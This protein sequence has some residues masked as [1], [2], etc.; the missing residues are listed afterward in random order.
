VVLSGGGAT[1]GPYK[2]RI[3]ILRDRSVRSS[4]NLDTVGTYEIMGDAAVLTFSRREHSD[5]VMTLHA[6][7]EMFDDTT[8]SIHANAAYRMEAIDEPVRY[9]GTFVRRLPD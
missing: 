3:F 5:F 4:R 8:P 7:G 9:Y 1:S 2:S 6:P